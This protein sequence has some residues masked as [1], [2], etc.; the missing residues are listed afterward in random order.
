MENVF[1]KVVLSNNDG[2]I[3]AGI[4]TEGDLFNMLNDV[5]HEC[6]VISQEPTEGLSGKVMDN[7]NSWLRY[8]NKAIDDKNQH[9]LIRLLEFGENNSSYRWDLSTTSMA[10]DYNNT[11][12]RINNF[13]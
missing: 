1:Y 4:V 8:I 6:R 13:S 7:M 11:M 9:E 5:D 10:E 12:D 3:W 2:G